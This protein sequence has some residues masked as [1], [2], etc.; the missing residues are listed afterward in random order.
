MTARALL[1]DRPQAPALPHPCFH[2]EGAGKYGR[3]H[4]P[5]A[6]LCNVQCTY[7]DRAYDCAHESR[8]G[9]TSAVLDPR[10]AAD[11]LHDVLVRMPW[12]SVA[13]IA[14]P[15]DA[16]AEPLRTLRPLN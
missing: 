7:C 5:V 6:P 14:G 9:V 10:E 1:A 11:H 16:F 15:G 13:G 3:I 2:P 4:L 8:Q 12:I